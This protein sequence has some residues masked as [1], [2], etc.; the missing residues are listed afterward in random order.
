MEV[1]EKVFDNI[2]SDL[3]GQ[4]VVLKYNKHQHSLSSHSSL[5]S[6]DSSPSKSG[7]TSHES[8][9]YFTTLDK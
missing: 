2:V 9:T 5:L 6:H 3:T 7:D 4:G 8:A 1:A